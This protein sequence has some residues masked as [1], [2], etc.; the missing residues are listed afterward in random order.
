MRRSARA[1]RGGR[2]ASGCEDLR[3]IPWVFGWM[4][5]RHALPAWFGVG[6]ALEK[7]AARGDMQEQQLR[8]MTR[9]SPC[10]PT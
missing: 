10:S 9:N 2:R 7:F 6:H 1:Q 3:A 4:Q 8:D 5:S